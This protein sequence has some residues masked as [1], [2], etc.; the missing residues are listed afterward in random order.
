MLKALDA[1]LLHKSE[2]GAVKVG[3]QCTADVTRAVEE[4]RTEM[5]RNAPEI[6]SNRLLVE[7]MAAPPVPV[8]ES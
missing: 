4:M 6:P 5:A 1:R 7:A 2:V 3:L 8:I